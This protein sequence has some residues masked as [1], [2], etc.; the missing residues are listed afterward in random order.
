MSSNFEVCLSSE[1]FSASKS[2]IDYNAK[3]HS[4]VSGKLYVNALN[5]LQTNKIVHR[6][7]YL[8]F[9][10]FLPNIPKVNQNEKEFKVNKIDSFCISFSRLPNY[11]NTQ[12]DKILILW[13][14]RLSD[15]VPK[16]CESISSFSP[17]ILRTVMEKQVNNYS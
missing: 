7:K 1:T 9:F 4:F 10:Y 8:F 15:K 5:D 2:E 17:K 16:T 11:F 14:W 12:I 3:I 13:S 6:D